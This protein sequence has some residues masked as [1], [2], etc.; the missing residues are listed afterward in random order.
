MCSA[1]GMRPGTRRAPEFTHTIPA[2][3]Y[4]N[5]SN[6]QGSWRVCSGLTTPETLPVLPPLR[7]ATRC[8]VAALMVA[9]LTIPVTAQAQ[10]ANT[11]GQW[12]RLAPDGVFEAG[13]WHAFYDPT[14]DCMIM[15]GNVLESGLAELWTVPL[16]G[17]GGIGAIV[18]T[19][20]GPTAGQQLEAAAYDS[21]R[22]QLLLYTSLE[23][24]PTCGYRFEVWA[25]SLRGPVWRRLDGN[26]IHGWAPSA[27][28]DSTNDRLLLFGGR[29]APSGA[30]NN[31][32]WA[33][34][35]S[36]DSPPLTT[37][38]TFA[39]WPPARSDHIAVYDPAGPRMLIY[40][41]LG[42]N[43]F[44]TDMWSYALSGT[45]QW[46]S[47]TPVGSVPPARSAASGVLDAARHRL[48]MYGG[49]VT[50]TWTTDL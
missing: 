46:S 10:A 24:C 27:I 49:N 23:V 38:P 4:T 30:P 7:C 17:N 41:G 34:P 32:M 22:D 14:R 16:T 8:F 12:V 40:G 36:P 18:P 44:L 1:E 48:L 21:K 31:Y 47:L 43:G 26:G 29:D 11:C 28:Y 25:V 20:D 9:I 39:P 45:Q 15:F 50:S 13:G 42:P 6:R 3:T 19:G 33:V 5:G 35:L 2:R 37:P